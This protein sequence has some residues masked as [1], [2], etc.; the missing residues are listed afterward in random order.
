MCACFR[1][2]EPVNA[3]E[4]MLQQHVSGVAIVESQGSFIGTLSKSPIENVIL[5]KLVGAKHA[6]ALLFT[7]RCIR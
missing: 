7:R 3:Y 1:R 2:D 5:G 6:I 4:F